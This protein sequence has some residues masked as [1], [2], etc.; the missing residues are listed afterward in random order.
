MTTVKMNSNSNKEN[1]K[2]TIVFSPIVG[3][4]LPLRW[5]EHMQMSDR[6]SVHFQRGT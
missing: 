3:R 2:A 6:C 5:K 4:L 1:V